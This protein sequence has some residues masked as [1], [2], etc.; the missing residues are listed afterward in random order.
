MLGRF[1]QREFLSLHRRLVRILGPS[2]GEGPRRDALAAFLARRGVPAAVDAAGNLVVC[3]GPP[4]EWSQ[5]LVLDAHLDVVER[6]GCGRPVYGPETV[7]GLGV[8]DDLAAVALLALASVRLARRGPALRRPVWALFSVGEEG[9]GNLR[10]MREVVA[11]HPCAPYLL[12][13]FDGGLDTGSMTGL[14]SRRFRVGI[15]C[16]GG[17]SWG[18]FGAPNAIDV[19]VG[20]LAAVKRRFLECQRTGGA[21]MSYNAGTIQGGEGINSIA[22]RAEAAL[23]FRSPSAGIL[24][25]LGAALRAEVEAAGRTP[26]VSAAWECIGERPAAGPVAPERVRAEVL[27]A[28]EAQGLSVPDRPMS[29]NINPALAAGWPAV[30]VGLCRSRHTHRE[31][32]TLFLPSLP[33]GWA[34]L[35]GLCTRLLG[36][37]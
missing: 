13:S 9:L 26:E 24:D 6:G 22:R 28:W 20:I 33:I 31:D 3:L 25:T 7:T 19:L 2:H 5:A 21:P 8:A 29:T 16:P 23:E 35:E 32:E 14:G 37:G 30:C 4:G 12:V 27:P 34:C 17:H 10:G 1:P 11:S 36:P 18:D 15:Q